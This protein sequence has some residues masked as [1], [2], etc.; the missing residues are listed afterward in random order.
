MASKFWSKAKDILVRLVGALILE[1][2]SKDQWA[3]S[4]GKVAWWLAFIPAIYI[5]SSGKG[6][7][8]DGGEALKDISPNHLKMLYTLAAYNFS[9]KGLEVAKKY[10]S[11]SE[12]NSLDG[13]G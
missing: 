7:L 2:D 3:I 11:K 4:T 12:P 10:L 1:K 13:P 9:K 5:W 6:I 8:G